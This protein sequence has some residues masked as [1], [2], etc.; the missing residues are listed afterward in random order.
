MLSTVT[1]IRSS[2]PNASCGPSL[3]SVPLGTVRGEL[4]GATS[5]QA[6]SADLDRRPQ[7]H[8]PGIFRA[9]AD[10][11]DPGPGHQ[12]RLRLH[13]DDG[14]RPGQPARVRDRSVRR[15]RPD[16]SNP[17]VRRVQAGPPA[18]ARRPPT[19]ARA[20]PSGPGVALDTNLRSAGLRG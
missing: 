18:D 15:G 11:H 17:G 7:P 10:E 16:L 2:V 14:Y 13:L 3:P 6:R 4:A 12:R 1:S 5:L 8:L 9:P 20:L 19:P